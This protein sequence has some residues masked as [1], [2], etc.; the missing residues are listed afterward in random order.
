MEFIKSL[1]N[2]EYKVFNVN[3]AKNLLIDLVIN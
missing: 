2:A 1:V 3:E